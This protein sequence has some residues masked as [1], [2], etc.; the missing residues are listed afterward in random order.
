M[1]AV[2][3]LHFQLL[4]GVNG[5]MLAAIAD[6]AADPLVGHRRDRLVACER[7]SAWQQALVVRRPA[8][9]FRL[10]LISIGTIALYLCLAIRAILLSG[11]YMNWADPIVWVTQLI[12]PATRGPAG[13]PTTPLAGGHPIS[14]E[15]AVAF[16]GGSLSGRP[17]EVD[18]HA[19]RCNRRLSGQAGRR[20]GIEHVLVG[21]DRERGSI[22]WCDSRHAGPRYEAGAGETFLDWQWPL[23]SGQEPFRITSPPGYRRRGTLYPV[24]LL[25]TSSL[26]LVAPSSVSTAVAGQRVLCFHLPA[27][28]MALLPGP[29]ATP[30]APFLEEAISLLLQSP[31]V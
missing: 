23:H 22:Q 25:P 18:L 28:Q 7:P 15:R 8:I 6:V 17:T 16:G 21:T 24:T 29:G 3:S 14:P 2:F 13:P 27:G 19:G 10:Y 1:D 20:A 11:A 5:V 4:A 9:P 12:S 26:S 31:I 30:R